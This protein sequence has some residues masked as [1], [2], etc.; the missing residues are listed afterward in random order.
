MSRI[1]NKVFGVLTAA[2]V[3]GAAAGCGSNSGEGSPAIDCPSLVHWSGTF[4]SAPPEAV[5][6]EGCVNERCLSRTTLVGP[7]GECGPDGGTVWVDDIASSACVG[8]HSVDPPT[9][10]VGFEIDLTQVKEQ[11]QDGDI[12]RLTVADVADGRL[13]VERMDIIDYVTSDNSDWCPPSAKQAGIHWGE[14][15]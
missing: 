14:V 6:I 7:R 2:A 11:L 8:M 13:L 12:G 10:L 15:P 3:S 9:I 5:V 4:E 1:R